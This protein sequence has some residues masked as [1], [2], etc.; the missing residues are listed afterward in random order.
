MTNIPPQ[1]DAQEISGIISRI[2]QLGS[3]TERMFS[4]LYTGLTRK[5]KRSAQSDN[6]DKQ[7]NELQRKIEDAT[8]AYE[9]NKAFANRLAERAIEIDRLS[10]ILSAI[11]E[12]IIMQDTEGR[13]VYMNT[14]AKDLLGTTKNFWSTELGMLFDA[15]RDITRVSTEITPLSEPTRVQVNN[16]I[17]GAQIAAVANDKGERLGTM[18]VLRDVTQDALANRLKD[19]FVTAI[20][21]ELK[22]PMTVIKGMSEVLISSPEDAPPNRRLLN[23][24]S[25]NVDIL[26]RMVVELLDISEMGADAFSIR[27]DTIQLEPLVWSVI[28]GMTPEM[29]EKQLDATVMARNVSQLQLIGDDQRLR[30]AL[31]HLVQNSTH[32]NEPGGNVMIA[33]G[34]DEVDDTKIV[35]DVI[36]SGVGIAEKDLPHIFERFYRGEPRTRSGKLLDPRG[37]GQG[38]FVA[39]TIAEAHQ[40]YLTVRSEAGQGSCFTM[41]LPT[42]QQPQA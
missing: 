2:N 16:R 10:G 23:T 42:E 29:K 6:N 25:R 38:L 7:R 27:N 17:V 36:D 40:G 41:V 11:D 37:L 8:R 12:G 32:Y 13:V 24:L 28:R 33:I 4:R 34:L 19:H 5:S 31:G 39:R 20:S 21:H 26:D 35:I 3:A 14:S 30:W 9:Q 22:T 18:V 15:Y 1:S